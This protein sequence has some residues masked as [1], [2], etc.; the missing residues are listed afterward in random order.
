MT[1]AR[2]STIKSLLS[3]KTISFFG[4]VCL[5]FNAATGPGIPY[6]PALFQDPGYIPAL[7]TF[8]LVMLLSGFSIL[9]TI[10]SLQ[11]IPG[12]AHFQGDVEY[13]T[14]INFYFGPTFHMIGQA[15][16]YGALQSNIVQAIIISVQTT[17]YL[18]ASIWKTCGITYQ[19]HSLCIS[20]ISNTSQASPFGSNNMIITFGLM[21]VLC[22]SI[23]LGLMNLDDNM[24]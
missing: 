15:I 10:E 19:F 11:A 5:L 6:T 3:S 21:V 14:L 24:W 22:L 9:F 2:K 20:E 23:P 18:F 16:L 7:A 8:F 1:I 12:N 13:A 4:S 17:D